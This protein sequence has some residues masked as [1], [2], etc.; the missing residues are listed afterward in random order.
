MSRLANS[1]RI[2]LHQRNGL[3]Y[4]AKEQQADGSF[5]SFSSPDES[6]FTDALSFQSVFS[7]ALI[8]SCLCQVEV[9]DSLRSIKQKLVSFLLAQKSP[10]W[11][12][13]YWNRY[14]VEARTLAY[15]DDLD[16][17]F[18]AL[19][20][21]TLADSSFINGEIMAQVVSIL[22]AGEVDEGGPYKTWI[23][24]K[25][26]APIWQ[27]VDAVVN[28]NIAYFL[29]LQGI[30]LPSL[31]R[32][33]DQI[34]ASSLY[35]SPY[36]PTPYPFL[37]FLSRFYQGEQCPSLISFLWEKRVAKR[38]QTPLA[39]ALAVCALLSFGIRTTLLSE[40]I[41]FLLDT[42]EKD[43]SWPAAV[44]YTGVNPKHDGLYFAGSPA[45]TTAFCLLAL[46]TYK[47]KDK[48]ERFPSLT[49]SSSSQ[50][51]IYQRI[52][53]EILTI[54]AS[55]AN[56]LKEKSL[57]MLFEIKGK[58]E[59]IFLL[60]YFFRCS[61]GSSVTVSDKLVIDL[62]VAT[63][64]GWIAYTIYDNF[65]DEEGDPTLL[66]LAS[67]CLRR[68]TAIFLSLFPHDTEFSAFFQEIMD[69]L[70]T[71]NTWETSYCRLSVKKKRISFRGIHLPDYGDFSFVSKKSFGHALGPLAICFAL[72]YRRNSVEVKRL[73]R[74]FHHYLVAKQLHDDAHD[75][76]SDLSRG[77]CTPVVRL[78]LAD[79]MRQ[80]PKHTSVR[81]TS[82]RLKT[83]F[84]KDTIT[85]VCE[86]ILRQA[87]SAREEVGT[88]SII[89]RPELL[90][91]LLSSIEAGAHRA[92]E[93]RERAIDFLH[94]Y[95][96]FAG[97]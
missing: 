5:V 54:F 86:E 37:Y 64:L 12:W 62:G 74:F 35:T 30:V 14:S 89:V 91:G 55:F 50:K 31:Q 52:E 19:T 23:V 78:L 4:L 2:A 58:S 75:V 80:Y 36:Y 84:W 10:Q 95:P 11:T 83:L 61:L 44:F 17:T 72:K 65:L 47:Q 3:E 68:L 71:A 69:S 59:Q 85:E 92:L 76:F 34:I 26:A 79:F 48:K 81:V 21:L 27:D 1:A 29:S 73:C 45:L 77:F 41:S 42:Q 16:D 38:W 67:L 9:S 70:D 90:L 88:L 13:N 94:A 49:V 40:P 33:F 51:K 7:S 22:V 6:D 15:P 63:I 32:Y 87:A 66:S 53:K 60:P 39:S 93:E 46:S 82:R 25:N 28:S 56:P 57:K 20:A 96:S 18:C 8:L 24:P 97:H 43:G